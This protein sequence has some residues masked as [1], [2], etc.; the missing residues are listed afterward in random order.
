MT[1]GDIYTVN[2]TDISSTGEGIG[3]VDGF[4]LFAPGLLTGETAKV[5][6]TKTGKSFGTAKVIEK[7]TLSD[8]R[9]SPPCPYYENCGGCNIMHLDYE[10]GLKYKSAAIVQNLKR[11]GKVQSIEKVDIIS[12]GPIFRYRNNMTLPVGYSKKGPYIG[13]FS[14]KSNDVVPI[15]DC[16]L[17]D[18]HLSKVIDIAEKFLKENGTSVYNPKTGKGVIRH[19]AYRASTQTGEKMLTCVI[20]ANYLI[21]SGVLSSKLSKIGGMKSININK[22]K[23]PDGPTLGNTTK[24]IYGQ[25]YITDFIGKYQFRITPETFFQVNP[26]ITKLMYEKLL[27]FADIQKNDTVLDAYCGVGAISIFISEYAEKVI[28]VEISDKSIKNAIENAALNRVLNTEFIQ[29]DAAEVIP[30]LLSRGTHP[31]V[32]IVDPPRKGLNANMINAITSAKIKKVVYI[33]CDSATLSRDIKQFAEAGYAVKAI[34]AFDMFCW[35]T[36]VETVVLLQRRDT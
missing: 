5:Q 19:I 23:K 16:L 30:D 17:A 12:A 3:R 11:I 34:T 7:I 20:N 32:I 18:V 9:I 31:N 22:N 1:I 6:V 24:N 13:L 35:T 25:E 10:E 26:Y 2:I 33:S 4:I 28:G 15:K 27:E 14:K 21:N 36:H 8:K 29:G